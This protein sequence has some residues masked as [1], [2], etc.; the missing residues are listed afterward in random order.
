MKG[1]LRR[2]FGARY[3][4]AALPDRPLTSGGHCSVRGHSPLVHFYSE[5]ISCECSPVLPVL[6]QDAMP[7]WAPGHHPR[8][9][10][11]KISKSKL[12]PCTIEGTGSVL[13]FTMRG[14]ANIKGSKSNI[15]MNAWLH[16]PVIP[17]VTF[18]T[19]LV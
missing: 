9:F 12:L 13:R 19:P 2:C 10:C 18:L 7:D 15:A 8:C 1:R 17:V 16:K 4:C 6:C 3:P 14:R 11:Q 5:F